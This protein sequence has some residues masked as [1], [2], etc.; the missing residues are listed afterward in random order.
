MKAI[1]Y[2]RVST[3]QQVDGISLEAQLAKIEAWCVVNDAELIATFDDAGLSGCRSDNRPGLQSALQLA[4]SEGAAVVVYSLSRLSRSTTDTVSIAE[5]LNSAGGDLV[6]LSE[7]IDTSSAA[8]KMV[9]RMLAVLNE[10]E[11]DQVSERTTAALQHKKSKGERVGT[12]PFGFRLADDGIKLIPVPEQQAVIQTI[13]ELRAAGETLQAICDHLQQ[14]KIKT[15][16]GKDRWTPTTI[17]R[18]IAA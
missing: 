16:K 7:K 5:R 17:R 15:A 12:V 6:S 9:F 3:E 8:G 4:C 14:R 2:L 11:R 10:F 18:L 13:R 1:A